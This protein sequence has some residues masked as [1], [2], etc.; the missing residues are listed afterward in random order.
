MIGLKRHTVRIVDYDPAWAAR[1]RE[2]A[3]VIRSALDALAVDV[4]HVGSTAVPGLMAKPILDIAV[5]V[6]ALEAIPEVVRR[7][8]ATGYIDRGD[9]GR[10]GGYLLARESEPE[11]RVVHTHLVCR[12]D[13]QWRNYLAF[14]DLLRSDPEIRSDYARLKR[15]LAAQFPNDRRSYTAGKEAFIRSA[16]ARAF[17]ES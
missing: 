4:Q 10:N 1:Y 16:L 5:A 8:V 14:R 2:E 17:S 7:L 12:D 15:E 6:E 9:A 11:V 13:D 3:R